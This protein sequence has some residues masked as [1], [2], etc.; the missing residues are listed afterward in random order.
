MKYIFRYTLLTHF[1]HKQDQ[2]TEEQLQEALKAAKF[3]LKG[4]SVSDLVEK[5]KKSIEDLVRKGEKGE[6]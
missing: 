6:V 2:I 1:T 5:S 3:A 4:R